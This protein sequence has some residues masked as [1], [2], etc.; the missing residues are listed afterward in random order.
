MSTIA[1][2]T[3]K[4]LFVF[5][6][7]AGCLCGQLDRGS[8]TGKITDP[9]GA[10]V[11]D[12]VITVTNI[13]T[14]VSTSTVSTS[15]GD[16]SAQALIVGRYRIT[17]ERAGFKRAVQ[18]NVT[19][20]AGST[21]RLDISLEIGS[22]AESIEVNATATPLETESTRVATNLPSRLVDELP[23][24]VAGQIRNVLSLATLAPEAKSDGNYSIG[25]GQ[26]AGWDV[27]MDGTSIAPTS[28]IYQSS[29]TQITAVSV[30]AISEFTVESTGLKA[31]FGRAM[32]FIN[33]ATK[34][35]TNA[36]HGN[37][38]EFLRND[39]L[40]ARGFF[41]KT[42]PV[43]KQHDF[44]GTFGGPVYLP[45]LYN[46]RD[47]TF[48][49][50]SYEG[51]RS[52]EGNSPNYYT[53]P[54]P[55]MY[56]GDF[57]G[58]VT[59]AGAQ[60][61]IYDPATTRLGTGG[62]YVRD[63]FA[64]NKISTSR[65]SQVAS[66]YIALRPASMVPNL[67]GPRLNY[68]LQK[69]TMTYPWNKGSARLDHR[70]S[71]K[72][73]VNFFFM[74][75]MNQDAPG[76]DGT[77]G[78][79]YPYTQS[80]ALWTRKMSSGRLTWNHM[81]TP[82]LLSTTRFYM[83]RGNGVILGANCS[84]PEQKWAA[85][86]G[87]K[88]VPGPDLCIPPV[89]MTEYSTWAG[90]PA[91]GSNGWDR[92]RDWSIAQDMSLIRSSHTFKGGFFFSK[93]QWDGGGQHRPNGNYDFTQLATAVPA[94]QSRNTGNAFASFLLGYA[95]GAGVETP[96]EVLMIWKHVGGFFQDDW[97][98]TPK[99]T[100]NMGLRYEYTFPNVGGGVVPDTEKG[101]SNFDPTVPNPGAGGL[102]GAFVFTG[103]GPGR[104]GTDY[105]FDGWKWAF[106][107]RLGLAYVVRTGTVVRLSAGRMFEA[108]K[109]QGGST[110]FDGFI[111]TF[112]WSS[113]DLSVLDFPM[114]LD[115][116]LP[117]YNRPPFLQPTVM[118]ELAINWWQKDTA[119]RPPDFW[120]W[121]FDIQQQV[122]RTT[123]FTARYSGSRGIHLTSGLL[124][125]NQIHPS[126]LKTLGPT[127]LRANI[128]SAAA[129]AAN[130]PIP[131]PTFNRTVQEALQ[132]FPQ[133]K[134]ISVGLEHT[135]NS[136]YNALV[137]VLDRRFSSGLSMLGS[138]TLSKMFSDSD[139]Q[140]G[141][142]AAIDFFNRKL[143]KGLT[144]SDQTH[145]IRQT[146][147]YELPFGRGK[148]LLAEGIAAHLAGGWSFAGVFE[149]A[150]GG[151]RSVS[152]GFTLP[153]GGGNRVFITSYENWRAPISGSKF[154]PF[155]DVWWQKS[156]FNQ[157]P[158]AVLD[159]ELGNA[160]RNNPKS[161]GPWQ[162][163]ENLS[164]AKS[165]PIR[166][167]I[168]IVF[169]FEAFNLLNRVRWSGPDSSLTSANFGLVRDQGNTPRQ[170]Q[171]ALKLY[172]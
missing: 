140:T 63:P 18:D 91:G 170:M 19:V 24:V 166:E 124:R 68:F 79:P 165:I 16:Y 126:Y 160:T 66:R 64:G 137:L 169:R 75:G 82:R 69:G 158:Q 120:T 108:V 39:R 114:M 8:V 54:L 61:Q 107:P 155:K 11:A 152:S 15:T 93:N 14:N 154:D 36:Y 112:T 3:C 51:F 40:D 29:R 104:T 162:L 81:F 85:K 134:T 163:R 144:G 84:N 41:A 156:S 23:L 116:G 123:V 45:K 122:T 77:P 5:A 6:A 171:A 90:Q 2:M 34:S 44:G 87:L 37:A 13:D 128:A 27:V 96:R 38:F 67:P 9:S 151:P 28:A 92:A 167:P 88:N 133:Y 71:S 132:P 59:A 25:G 157:V 70:L 145:V 99:L 146:F 138:Y 33:F 35:G 135:G 148:S 32:G 105:P 43:L 150:S 72:D 161:R 98:V 117:A 141:G 109:T 60:I 86:L 102:P 48:F 47:R 62:K 49:F 55:A 164:I 136:T 73:D 142:S 53:I 95:S 143:E 110:H 115:N 1:G 21:I 26:Q 42:R 129:R 121:S 113:S 20:S 30:D 4:L 78:L 80:P 147:T 31:E 139:S 94:D 131:Y 74:K 125:P 7:A 172:F 111:G 149:Y 101:F 97:R 83:Q 12:A 118:N 130:I 100:V 76:P 106:G 10:F 22:V 50:L 46:G 168:R 89:S 57:T 159:T 58:W 56:E 119:G 127:L 153:F 52:R 103:K 65:Y 17:A